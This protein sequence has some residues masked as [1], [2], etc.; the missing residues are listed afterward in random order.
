GQCT[1]AAE[2]DL[3]RTILYGG[4]VQ[5]L[6]GSMACI[7]A[8]SLRLICANGDDLRTKCDS[9]RQ[10]GLADR[11][12]LPSELHLSIGAACAADHDAGWQIGKRSH[13]TISSRATGHQT[14]RYRRASCELEMDLRGLHSTQ[15][16]DEKVLL[17]LLGRGGVSW[18]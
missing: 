18:L 2:A 17:R 14:G 3:A 1:C 10:P 6:P 16:L 11:S 8:S 9:E 15:A 5:S 13:V 7:D 12:L 4:Q